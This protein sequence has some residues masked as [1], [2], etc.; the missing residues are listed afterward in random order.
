MNHLCKVIRRIGV[1]NDSWN[2]TNTVARGITKRRNS[3]IDREHI[4]AGNEVSLLLLLLLYFSVVV[5]VLL[6]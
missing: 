2:K 1:L 3:S 5:E 4:F 6:F